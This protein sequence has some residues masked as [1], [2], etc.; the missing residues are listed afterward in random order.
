MIDKY[1]KSLFNRLNSGKDCGL[2]FIRT[3][4]D[5]VDYAKIWTDKPKR[6]DNIVLPDGPYKF[7]FLLPVSSPSIYSSIC[8]K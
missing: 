1:L 2:I 3:L 6:T 4:S 8:L 5:V 7:Y